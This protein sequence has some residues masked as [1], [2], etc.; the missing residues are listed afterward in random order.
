M[1]EAERLLHELYGARHIAAALITSLCAW[2]LSP[3]T[4][5]L[6]AEST[7]PG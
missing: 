4:G 5:T 6:A 3:G 2:T 1:R 7:V